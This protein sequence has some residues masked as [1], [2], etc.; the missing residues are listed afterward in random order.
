MLD[1][2]KIG[3]QNSAGAGGPSAAWHDMARRRATQPRAEPGAPRGKGS[4]IAPR[5]RRCQAETAG[6]C[7]CRGG[8]QAVAGK[9]AE[10]RLE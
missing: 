4:M 9:N 10:T 5:P 6:A 3:W 1:S 7:R 2:L 8:S